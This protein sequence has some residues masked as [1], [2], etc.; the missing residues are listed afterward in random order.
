M[1]DKLQRLLTGQVISD[2]MDKTVLVRVERTYTHPRL[3]KVMRTFKKYKVH[4][5]KESAA[6]GDIVEFYE[7]RPL[8]KTKYMYLSRIIKTHS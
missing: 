6:P 5:E 4:D 7:G 2:K 8:S 1:K 3:N